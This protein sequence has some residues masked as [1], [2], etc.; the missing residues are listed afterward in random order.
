MREALHLTE[1]EAQTLLGWGAGRL[2]LVLVLCYHGPAESEPL[3]MLG[4]N[5]NSFRHD[6]EKSES[7]G[8]LGEN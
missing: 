3:G 5:K 7:L 2:S 1:Y 8:Y 4:K 6:P